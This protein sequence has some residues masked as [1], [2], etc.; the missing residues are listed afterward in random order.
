MSKVLQMGLIG[1]I[2]VI[3]G[4]IISTLKPPE[5][6]V[7]N[8]IGYINDVIMVFS[9]MVVTVLSYILLNRFYTWATKV[10]F[11]REDTVKNNENLWSL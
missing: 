1:L 5:E 2:I 7:M 4:L 3:C 6:V 9:F 10:A 11:Y 8:W